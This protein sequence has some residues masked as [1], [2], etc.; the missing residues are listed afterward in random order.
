MDLPEIF[1][2]L[3][4]L[5]TKEKINI[6]CN[7]KNMF[8]INKS[9]AAS[10]SPLFFHLIKENPMLQQISLPINKD[11]QNFFKGKSIKKDLFLIMS[12]ILDNKE[13]IQKWKEENQINK[14]NVIDCLMTFIKYKGKVENIEEGIKYIGEHYEELKNHLDFE[15]IP[16][17]YLCE[18]SRSI[19]GV[20]SEETISKYIIE[21]L[22]NEN[23]DKYRRKLIDSI[24]MRGL[25]NE[26]IK[27]LIEN[28]KYNDLSETLFSILQNRLISTERQLIR[29][30]RRQSNSE[31][32]GGIKELSLNQISA[33]NNSGK[34]VIVLSKKEDVNAIDI[35]Y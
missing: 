7:D 15:K 31:I 22:K 26:N 18:I 35:I 21:R 16:S 3:G 29:L 28:L 25:N 6:I 20:K 13:L 34:I 1:I 11:S 24:E 17:E 9:L 19:K 14:E 23:Q 10:I 30:Q 4:Q 27:E 32:N 5:H 33:R 12:I 2:R 8:S